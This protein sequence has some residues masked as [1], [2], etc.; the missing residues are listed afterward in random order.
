MACHIVDI[1]KSGLALRYL[2]EDER[3]NNIEGLS[4]C[5]ND[6]RYVE[7]IPVV[8]VSD[9]LINT[10][11]FVHM[12]RQGIKFDNLTLEQEVQLDE[13]ISMFTAGGA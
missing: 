9:A 13:F 5:I 4:I 12:R 3:P 6:D 7:N 8:K 10:N 1:S 2:G 11:G